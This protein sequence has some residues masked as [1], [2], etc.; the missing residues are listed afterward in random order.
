MKTK[1]IISILGLWVV[2][3]AVCFASPHMGTWK[4]NEAKSKLAS[5]MGKNSTVV[6]AAAGDSVKVTVDGTDKDGKATHSEWTGKFD[7]KDYAVTG[8]STA[9]MRSYKQ[10]NDQTLELTNK[11][12]GKVTMSGQIVVSA[13][14]KTRTVTISGTDAQGKKIESVALYDKQ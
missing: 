14:G 6:Y 8:D 5:G 4:L 11:K 12:D 1:T 10:A 3:A 13:D 9:D 2:G 7:G